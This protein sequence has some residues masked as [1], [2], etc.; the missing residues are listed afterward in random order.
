MNRSESYNTKQ[1]ETIINFIKK[2]KYEFTIKDIHDKNNENVGLTTI[3]RVVDKLIS[4]GRIRKSIKNN[5]IYYQ[6]LEKCNNEN[7]FYL[8]CDTCGKVFHTDCACIERMSSHIIKDH[9][10]KLNTN[11]III[12]GTCQKCLIKGE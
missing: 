11:N 5:I 7:H 8:K 9:G 2:Q 3:Y 12:S 4:E 1:K 6:Y 10:F